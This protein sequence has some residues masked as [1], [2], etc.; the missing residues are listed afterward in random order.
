MIP[1]FTYLTW[2]TWQERLTYAPV[3]LLAYVLL[4]LWTPKSGRGWRWYCIAGGSA[5]LY[6]AVVYVLFGLR[7][8]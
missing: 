2:P 7:L 5:L 1:M 8:P 6:L 3:A 4:F